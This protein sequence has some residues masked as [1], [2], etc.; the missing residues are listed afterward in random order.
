[1]ECRLSHSREQW[2]CQIKIRWEYE[3][4]G[5]SPRG[6]V[7]EVDFGPLLV[8]K[9]QVEPLLR[10]AQAAILS[11]NTPAST[12]VTMG[13]DQLKANR[14]AMPFSRNVVC[15]ELSGPE[16]AD[17]SFVDLPGECLLIQ[18]NYVS[19]KRASTHHRYR[20][21]RRPGHSPSRREPCQVVHR[22]E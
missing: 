19:T 1:M 3:A 15:V 11:P 20:P 12:F 5:R 17:L 21:E 8:D 16:L 13:D 7:S 10:R 6:E 9:A 18:G 2:S 14:S 22:R 4:D